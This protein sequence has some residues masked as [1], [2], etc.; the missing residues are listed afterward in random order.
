MSL[1]GVEGG[2]EGY[3]IRKGL[4]RAEGKKTQKRKIIK[5]EK[6]LHLH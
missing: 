4:S 6:G 3:K 1:R 5:G 2:T